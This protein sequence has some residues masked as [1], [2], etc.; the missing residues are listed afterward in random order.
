MKY[1]VMMELSE[2]EYEDRY[3]MLGGF[4]IYRQ[5]QKYWI[6]HGVP[7]DLNRFYDMVGEWLY[8]RKYLKE[9]KLHSS[10]D[11]TPFTEDAIVEAAMVVENL[12]RRPG[13]E[14]ARLVLHDLLK[15]WCGATIV[16]H[17]EGKHKDIRMLRIKPKFK[18][19]DIPIAPANSIILRNGTIIPATLESSWIRPPGGEKV[20]YA[21]HHI[22]KYD[23]YTKEFQDYFDT[24]VDD[25][26]ENNRRAFDAFA[27]THGK[28]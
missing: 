4:E 26:V 28:P 16:V 11:T 21:T 7:S 27:Q 25:I 15:D 20:A 23:S 3:G 2:T 18:K 22:S 10:M 14:N 8:L 19:E 1:K 6:N 24:V 17:R 13:V 9:L 12:K 5:H